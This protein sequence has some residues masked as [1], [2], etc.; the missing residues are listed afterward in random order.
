[1]T[2]SSVLPTT[3]TTTPASAPTTSSETKPLLGSRRAPAPPRRSTDPAITLRGVGQ[4]M[5]VASVLILI[6]YVCTQDLSAVPTMSASAT[7]PSYCPTVAPQDRVILFWQTEVGG[8]DQVPD[9]VTHVLFG[10]SQVFQGVLDPKLQSPQPNIAGCVQALRRRCIYSMGVIGGANNN[11]GM[12]SINNPA[13]FAAN[14]KAYIDMYLFDGVDIDDETNY[15]DATYN[16]QR[17]LAYMQA[18]HDTL[19]TNGN[20]YVLSYD[21]YMLEADADCWKGVTLGTRCFARGIESLVDWVNVMAYNLD[22]DVAVAEVRDNPPT[23]EPYKGFADATTTTFE[24]WA[25]L[26]PREKLALGICMGA[27]CAYGPGPQQWVIESWTQ[28]N[29]AYKMGGMMIYAGS[30]DIDSG[31][32]TTKQIVKWM[33]GNSRTPRLSPRPYSQPPPPVTKAPTPPPATTTQVP[34]P[35]RDPTACGTCNNCYYVPL[36]ACY[37]GWTYAQCS[38]MNFQWCGN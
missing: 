28:Y 36:Q 14:V 11:Y 13:T 1:M 19:K 31:F 3:T 4:L 30:T 38:S 7:R 26:V 18:L 37:V 15:R 33:R 9:G 16:N 21:A 34:A 29:Y 8:C 6:G 20:N 10:F 25:H 17:V 12:G 22:S 35:P 23:M 24:A 27:A 32:Y 2:S 5:A